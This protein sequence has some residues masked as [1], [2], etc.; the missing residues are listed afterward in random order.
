MCTDTQ[1]PS[2]VKEEPAFFCAQFPFILLCIPYTSVLDCKIRALEELE[3][4]HG[5]V[6]QQV[7]E[8]LTRLLDYSMAVHY[9]S[10]PTCKPEKVCD[11]FSD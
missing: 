11:Q 10:T 4:G 5:H 1:Y 3:V 6:I 2:V 8:F 9:R 7:T